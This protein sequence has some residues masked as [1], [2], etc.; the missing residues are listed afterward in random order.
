M[1]RPMTAWERGGI[2]ALTREY[3]EC[4]TG[5]HP[6]GSWALIMRTMPRWDKKLYRHWLGMW[7]GP[8]G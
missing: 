4:R 6:A 7:R 8:K 2:A 1:Y 3:I 5:R